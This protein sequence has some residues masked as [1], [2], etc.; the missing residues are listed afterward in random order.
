[1]EYRLRCLPGRFG[2]CWPWEQIAK[3]KRMVAFIWDGI[4]GM[5][6]L[7]DVLHGRGFGF[8]RL[9]VCT[10]GRGVSDDGTVIAGWGFNPSGQSEGWIAR[11]NVVPEPDSSLS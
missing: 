1:M 4:N 11:L 5:R 6:R 8:D 10:L 7:Q 9:E 2:G 3:T